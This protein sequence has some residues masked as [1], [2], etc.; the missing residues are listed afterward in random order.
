MTF[1][2]LERDP[3]KAISPVL[4]QSPPDRFVDSIAV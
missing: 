2:L 3:P 1:S 4:E